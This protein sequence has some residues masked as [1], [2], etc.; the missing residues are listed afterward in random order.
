M[1]KLR[2]WILDV[3][4]EVEEGEPLIWIW[5]VDEG[6]SRVVVKDRFK[7]EFYVAGRAPDALA[8]CI[9]NARDLPILGVG[10]VERKLF[11]KP[12]KVVRVVSLTDEMDELVKK[13][14]KVCGAEEVYEADVRMSSQFLLRKGVRPSSW[15]EVEA[16]EIGLVDGIPAYE[17]KGE[18]TRVN[19]VDIPK[20]KVLAFDA[21]Y[22][23]ERGSPKPEKN[24]VIV[25]SAVTDAGDEAQFTGDEKELLESYVKFVREYDPDVIVGF[26]T[27]RRH[28]PYLTERYKRLGLT[29]GIG[30]LGA[31]PRTSVYG[32]QSVQGRINID[33][34]DLAE[35]TPEV[36]LETLEEYSAYLGLPVKYDT[37]EEY[38]L[39]A[40]W[41]ENRAAVLKY[42]MQRA[43]G[44]MEVYKAV[45]D[46][47]FSLSEITALP[48]DHVL[49]A[50]TGFR[51]ESRLMALAV[52][53]AEL[54][55]PRKEV[56]HV[57]YPGGMV[58]EPKAGLHEGVAV[59]DFKSMYPSLMMK[60]NIS[61]DTLDEAGVYKAPGLPY[62]FSDKPG[63]I[64]TALKRLVEERD[65]VRQLAKKYPEG[66]VE[67]RVLEA[68]QKALKVIANATYGYTG[69]IGARWYCREVAESTTAWG[70]RTIGDAIAKAK[71]LGLEVIYGDTDSL[72]VK[73]EPAKVERLL[74][75]INDELGLEAKLEKVYRRIVFTEAKKRYGGLTEDGKLE[76]VGLEAV[77]GD[78]SAVAKEA[79]AAVI[80]DLLSKG[81]SEA[82]ATA[83]RYLKMVR[84]GNAPVKKLIIWKQITKSLDEYAAA[85]PHVVVA[86]KMAELGWEVKPGDKVGF[87]VTKKPGKLHEKAVPY[88]EADP[89]QVD[90]DY[91]VEKQVLPPI[92][93]VL[94]AVGVTED[95]IR[96]PGVTTL[97]EFFG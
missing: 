65:A 22:L 67:R 10:V 36:K 41:K 5:G 94:S 11:G 76:I 37:V 81:R 88:F 64:P 15:V 38:E 56:A 39:A 26:G 78:W 12:I 62:A 96:R 79:Q 71:E 97:T 33:L 17:A 35:E 52:D 61:F 7:P 28:I 44:I 86:R 32:H 13:L 73:Y 70:R 14:K 87:I 47:I 77:R 63:F 19:R 21:F 48:A 34:L 55:P 40:V 23:A 83:R 49:T 53:V 30:R 90:W 6:G 46:F 75:W 66:S 93:R 80:A 68:R 85:A 69:W 58:I 29:F 82:V 42:S 1:G 50:A 92:V 2:F 89:S 59:I 72:F 60:Y 74:K 84:E 16:E 95:E 24:P 27:N 51:V 45:A 91:Y 9:K 43:R 31:E 4:T 54:I 25:V 8:S 57:T 20:L 3:A 18:Y